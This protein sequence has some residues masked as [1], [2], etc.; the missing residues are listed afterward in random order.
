M[1]PLLSPLKSLFSPVFFTL[2]PFFEEEMHKRTQPP[3]ISTVPFH[4]HDLLSSTFSHSSISQLSLWRYTFLLLSQSAHP[5][6]WPSVKLHLILSF[7]LPH[8]KTAHA[9]CF[10]FFPFS[11]LLPMQS[12]QDCFNCAIQVLF[13]L[14]P[15]TL[16]L[17][18]IHLDIVKPLLC[19]LQRSSV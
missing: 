3:L 12:C 15:S 2:V 14:Y 7:P 11:Y 19:L 1:F 9:F 8:K 4:P 17:L 10:F 16:N 13:P 5:S 18:C 6:V